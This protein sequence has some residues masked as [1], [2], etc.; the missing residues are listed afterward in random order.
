MA[1]AVAVVAEAAV[2]V[3]AASG[4]LASGCATLA[5]MVIPMR[6]VLGELV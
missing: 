2:A 1:V 5:S 4:V 3:A 6:E